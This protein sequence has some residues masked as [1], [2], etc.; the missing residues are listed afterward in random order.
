MAAHN[1]SLGFGLI[2]LN[3]GRRDVFI[4]IKYLEIS[5][6]SNYE[7]VQETYHGLVGLLLTLLQSP[8]FIKL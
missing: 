4:K 7:E 5:I 2:F 1:R 3:R 8:P 6:L